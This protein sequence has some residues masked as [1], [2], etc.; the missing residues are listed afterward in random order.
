MLLYTILYQL[1]VLKLHILTIKTRLMF[2][3]ISIYILTI[4][5]RLIYIYIYSRHRVFFTIDFF[6]LFLVQKS[7]FQ[8]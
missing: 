5:T 3:Y 4:K 2:V 6:L 8:V 7:E 1:E